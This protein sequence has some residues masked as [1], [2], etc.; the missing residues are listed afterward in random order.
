[1]R[2]RGALRIDEIEVAGPRN[3]DQAA[4]R[5]RL[6]HSQRHAV[7]VNAVNKGDRDGRSGQRRGIG[8][9]ITFGNVIR[10]APHQEA[11]RPSA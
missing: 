1:M 3:F 11:H 8:D 4:C 2:P 10:P 9:G 7:I 6:A 5:E